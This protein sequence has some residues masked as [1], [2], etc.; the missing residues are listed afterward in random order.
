M[1]TSGG[2]KSPTA[3][4]RP[5]VDGAVIV[6]LARTYD[7]V[8]IRN[9]RTD[10]GPMVNR[11]DRLAATDDDPHAIP[12]YAEWTS[13]N[14]GLLRIVS[15]ENLPSSKHVRGRTRGASRLTRRR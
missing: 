14:D 2:F 3:S 6:F 4:I 7:Q 10:V 8:F 11:F 12:D 1:L 5:R 15:R 13:E 9:L